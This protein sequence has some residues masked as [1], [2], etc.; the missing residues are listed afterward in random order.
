MNSSEIGAVIRA[1][2]VKEKVTLEEMAALTGIGINTLSRLE[3][4]V[5]NTQLTVLLKVLE[6]LGLELS[7]QPRRTMY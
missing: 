4:G 2:R 6:T 7:V 3:R 1:R 5:G